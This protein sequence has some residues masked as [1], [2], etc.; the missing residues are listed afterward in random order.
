MLVRTKFNMYEVGIFI[1]YYLNS[2]L[3]Y[4]DKIV[5]DLDIES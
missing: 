2:I 1:L 3:Y 4:F 5:L